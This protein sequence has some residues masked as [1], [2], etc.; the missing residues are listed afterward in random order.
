M[1]I[2]Q[3][4]PSEGHILI[5]DDNPINLQILTKQ[6]VKYGYTVNV[7]PD[8]ATSLLLINSILPD[9]ILLDILMPGMDGYEVCK[10]L[11]ADEKTRHIPVIFLS[12]L[13]EVPDKIKAFSVGGADFITKPF[14][15]QEILVRIK[16]QLQLLLL[17]RELQQQKQQLV[18]QNQQLQRE[19][20]GRDRALYERQQAEVALAQERAY[21]HR[22]STRLSTLIGSLQAGIL[23]E[24]EHRRI[25]LTNQPFCDFFNIPVSPQQLIG[26]DYSQSAEQTKALFADPEAFLERI[27]YILRKREIVVA[28]AI[29]LADGRIFERDYIPILQD[30]EYQGHLWQY[31]DITARK[32]T[33]MEL[34]GKTKALAD[35]SASLKHLHRLNMTAFNSLDELFAN[36]IQTGCEILEFSAGAVGRVQG[37]TYTFLAVQSEFEH[38]VPNLTIDLQD[39]FCGKVLERQATVSLHHVGQLEDMRCHPLYRAL[40]LESYLGTPIVV[41]GEIFGTLCFFSTQ[42][43]SQMFEKHEREI[44]ELMAQS[45]GKFIST[46]QIEA[47]QRQAKEAAIFEAA[48]SEDANRTKSEFLAN[49]SHE[50]RTP[51]N[52]ILGFTQLMARESSLTQTAHEYLEIIGRSGKHLLN[53]I[54]DV[55]EMSKI[56]AGQVVLNSSCFDLYYLL[57]TLEKMLQLGAKSK[58]LELSFNC[59]PTVPQYIQTDEG[60]LRQVLINLLG[61]AIKFTQHGRVT[62]RVATEMV[63]VNEATHGQ[64]HETTCSPVT[65]HFEVEDSGIGIDPHELES[66]FEPFVQ[67]R[68]GHIHEGTGLGLSISRKFVQLIGG[69]ITVSSVLNQGTVVQFNV[70]VHL[71]QSC[72][73]LTRQPRQRAIALTPG[74]PLFRILVAEDHAE[75]RQLLVRLLQSLTFDVREATNGEAAIAIWQTWQPHLIWMDMR[76]PVINGFEATQQIRAQEQECKSHA[77]PLLHHIPTK[78]IALTASAF[79]EDRAKVLAVGCDDFVRK[80]FREDVIV[81]KISEHLGVHYDYEENHETLSVGDEANEQTEIREFLSSYA[82]DREQPYA[83]HPL[84]LNVMPIEWIRQ[85]HQAAVLGSD[86]QLLQLVEQIP[87]THTSLANSLTSWV[88]NFQ[89]DHLLTLTQPYLR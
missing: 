52:A 29:W 46:Q 50:L 54:N 45:L 81:E 32:V 80:P 20:G 36:Y 63:G 87:K 34:R 67:S 27:Q 55:L 66:L 13:E 73:V 10:K 24:D 58:G 83:F 47:K 39:A 26:M 70:Q 64:M 40:K 85:V 53:L 42:E 49:M 76:M 25:V 33:E 8:G 51:L 14:Q 62:L 65:L 5:V 22:I 61:N 72:D 4:E 15:L 11:K 77:Q 19:I 2:E 82:L 1:S 35:F 31:R 28:E 12:A 23:V 59:A 84:N 3:V 78:I 68:S 38:L 16:H 18:E 43:R 88:R 48:R 44:I 71:A 74:Q 21:L 6:L 9:L 57:Q 30:Q 7:A 41:D 60:K 89:F 56:E 79:E 17:Q 69:D 86:R 37:Q 75:S